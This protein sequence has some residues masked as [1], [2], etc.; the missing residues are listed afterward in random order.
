MIMDKLA[1]IIDEGHIPEEEAIKAELDYSRLAHECHRLRLENER[2]RR[3]LK[4]HRLRLENER[5][6]RALDIVNS[7]LDTLEREI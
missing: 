6:R 5:M 1:S 3:A 2:M 7:T 4:C